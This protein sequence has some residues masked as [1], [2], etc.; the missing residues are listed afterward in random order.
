MAA[1]R[2][3]TDLGAIT[4]QRGGATP[5]LPRWIL[6]VSKVATLWKSLAIHSL[7][8]TFDMMQIVGIGTNQKTVGP[9][10]HDLAGSSQ[11]PRSRKMSCNY[12]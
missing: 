6:K 7:V 4:Q 2:L 3:P 11:W 10:D 5:P 12:D 8:L 1:L 9:R